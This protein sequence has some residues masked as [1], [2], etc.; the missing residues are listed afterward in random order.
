MSVSANLKILEKKQNYVAESEIVLQPS[1]AA[2]IPRVNR[3]ANLRESGS[4]D[5]L[6]QSNLDISTL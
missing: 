1:L 2:T 3:L 4:I 5:K 6:V